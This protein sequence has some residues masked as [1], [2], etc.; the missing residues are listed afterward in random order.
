MLI[1]IWS[2]FLLDHFSASLFLDGYADEAA[3]L[4][5]GAIVVENVRIAQQRVQHEP[6]VATALP[7]A[8]I[9]DHLLAGGNALARRQCVQFL[10][11]PEGTI[12][13][14]RQS[15]QR[16]GNVSNLLPISL[17]IARLSWRVAWVACLTM[18]RSVPLLIVRGNLLA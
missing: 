10:R 6:G 5:P 3:P 15:L 11:R 2:G 18:L 14:S 9:D 8:T 12:F 4:G 17:L 7:D 1:H 13:V 16:R